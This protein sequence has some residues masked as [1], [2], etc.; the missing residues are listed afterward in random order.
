MGGD[1]MD[2]KRKPPSETPEGGTTT[3]ISDPGDKKYKPSPLQLS[4]AIGLTYAALDQIPETVGL[5][6]TGLMVLINEGAD[7]GVFPVWLLPYLPSGYEPVLAKCEA[8]GYVH[9]EPSGG[10]RVLPAG[11]IDWMAKYLG[12]D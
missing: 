11:H 2:T 1:P 12:D 5:D 9:V 7:E 10:V 4:D 3:T 6:G 8:A